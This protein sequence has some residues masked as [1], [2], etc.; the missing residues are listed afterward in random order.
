MLN[1]SETARCPARGRTCPGKRL[2]NR[3]LSP[4]SVDRLTDEYVKSIEH[5]TPKRRARRAPSRDG[6]DSETSV[7][8]D[9]PPG[10]R[11]KLGESIFPWFEQEASP[12]C[13]ETHIVRKTESCSDSTCSTRAKPREAYSPRRQ[14]PQTFLPQ[15][16]TNSYEAK[17][18]A[19]TQYIALSDISELLKRIEAVS[20]TDSHEIVLGVSAPNRKVQ[21]SGQW[22]VA[23]NIYAKALHFAF[24][25]RDVEFQAYISQI[26]NLFTAKH[27]SAHSKVIA[28]DKAVRTRVGGGTRMLLTDQ[29]EFVDLR[30][31][32]LNVDGINYGM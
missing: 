25:D 28:Y 32:T 5:D 23:A 16:G 21:T 30:D 13:T 26:L 8:N 12:E 17:P 27:E 24:P 9:E 3:S 19:L 7:E 11:A 15:S 6:N 10:K 4:Q 22:L 29:Q 20:D 31:S 2:K 18:H 1:S 14:L